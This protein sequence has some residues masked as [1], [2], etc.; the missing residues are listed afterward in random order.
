MPERERMTTRL[1]TL[2]RKAISRSLRDWEAKN[3]DK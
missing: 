3:P 2:F 1:K